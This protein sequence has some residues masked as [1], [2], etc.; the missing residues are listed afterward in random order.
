MT[1]KQEHSQSVIKTEGDTYEQNGK[2]G[3]GHLNNCEIQ[4]GAKLA[5]VINEAPSNKA[6]AN[7]SIDNQIQITNIVQHNASP[8]T[9]ESIKIVP[10]VL[11]TLVAIAGIFTL[12]TIYVE[13]QKES[14]K[15]GLACYENSCNGRDPENIGCDIGAATITSTIASFPELGKEFKNFQIEMRHSDKCNASWVRAKAPIGSTLYLEGK[16]GKKYTE[17]TIPDD[18]ITEPH[19]TDMGSGNVMRRACVKASNGKVQCTS[20]VN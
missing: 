17:F 8:Q 5:G 7:P 13:F 1:D 2:F 9:G 12:S 3:A 6:Q 16:D 15:N 11:F 10:A 4:D 14:E 19:Y 20:F 18:G